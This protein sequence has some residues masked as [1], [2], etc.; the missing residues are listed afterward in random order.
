MPPSFD[1]R[2]S[3]PQHYWQFTAAAAELLLLPL[4]LIAFAL[5][6]LGRERNPALTQGLHQNDPDRARD[7]V[8]R[9]AV[10]RVRTEA[11]SLHLCRLQQLARALLL[12]DI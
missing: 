1:E 10:R 8:K 2:L 9:L 3:L 5:R 12:R 6:I 7:S 11:W 4:P